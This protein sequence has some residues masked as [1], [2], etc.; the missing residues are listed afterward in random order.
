MLLY[1]ISAS[2]DTASFAILLCC[3]VNVV[4]SHCASISAV[5]ASPTRLSACCARARCV[6]AYLTTEA[7]R[8]ARVGL[9]HCSGEQMSV[10]DD[11]T[12]PLAPDL[13]T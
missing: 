7:S 8:F 6:G 2:S 11:H 1:R 5:A 9:A 3:V 13:R 12:V 4:S 10:G